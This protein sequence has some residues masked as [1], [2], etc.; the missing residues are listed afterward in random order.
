MLDPQLLK[1]LVCPETRT[2]LSLA[3]DALMAKLN[4]AIAAGRVANQGGRLLTDILSGGLVCADGGVLYPI[5]DDIPVLLIDERIPLGPQ[6]A[7]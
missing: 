3:D 4:A 7:D 5:V 6:I 1:I 2:P